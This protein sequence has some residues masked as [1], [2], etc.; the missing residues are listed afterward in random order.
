MRFYFLVIVFLMFVN[1]FAQTSYFKGTI[2]ETIQLA[3]SE[4]KR[5]VL[6][7]G[8][9][10][11]LVCEKLKKQFF[12]NVEIG[13][14]INDHFIVR[15]V[16]AVVKS[17]EGKLIYEDTPDGRLSK[18]YE[19]SGF[20]MVVIVDVTDIKNPKQVIRMK[21]INIEMINKKIVETLFPVDQKYD[22]KIDE[23]KK[24]FEK[25]SKD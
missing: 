2:E 4:N 22:Y 23:I 13:K 18:K 6:V 11:C 19:V 9:N 15:E 14:F 12:E 17:E 5:L 8:N 16:R 3:N 21:G 10:Y 24:V 7:F 20:P 25:Y 1:S